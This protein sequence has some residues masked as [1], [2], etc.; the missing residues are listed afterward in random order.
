M[1][2][3]L[4]DRIVAALMSAV[5]E[6][7]RVLCV[8]RIEDVGTVVPKARFLVIRAYMVEDPVYLFWQ[9]REKKVLEDGCHVVFTGIAD[10]PTWK[11]LEE[12]YH[13]ARFGCLFL[14][15]YNDHV[16]VGVRPS[17]RGMFMG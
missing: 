15:R 10:S 11:D 17:Q 14:M 3:G 9:I 16:R 8:D 5:P 7:D 12:V 4:E 1:D 2:E 6:V 13:G